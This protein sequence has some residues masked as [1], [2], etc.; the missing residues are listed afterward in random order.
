[1][2]ATLAEAYARAYALA[3]QVQ[4]AGKQM[5]DDIGWRGLEHTA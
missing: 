5:R 3:E 4:F 2:G 1:L